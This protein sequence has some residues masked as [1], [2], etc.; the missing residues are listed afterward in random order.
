MISLLSGVNGL[1]IS[2]YWDWTGWL[3][4]LAIVIYAITHE[5]RYIRR[6][7][8]E[9]VELGVITLNQYYTAI[10]AL[11][12]TRAR[13]RSIFLGSFRTTNRFY[14]RCAELAHKKQHLL[15]MGDENGNQGLIDQLRS[16]LSKLSLEAVA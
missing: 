3:F 13:G 9:E 6:N 1:I 16:E 14:H 4:M 5:Q 2:T 12:Q 15:R 7:L 11:A 8:R 10:S